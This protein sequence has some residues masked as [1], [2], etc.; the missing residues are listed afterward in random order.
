ML[1]KGTPSDLEMHDM[2][3]Q[4]EMSKDSVKNA[5]L[6]IEQQSSSFSIDEQSMYSTF[7]SKNHGEIGLD[8]PKRISD[9]SISMDEQ[10]ES[11]TI[12]PRH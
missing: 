1:G 4:K 3:I 5:Y 9:N 8:G 2:S 7:G 10:L 12:N 6:G 11:R